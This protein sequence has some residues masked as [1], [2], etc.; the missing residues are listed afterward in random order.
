MS[1]STNTQIV[2]V[3]G[4]VEKL[5]FTVIEEV[6]PAGS[7]TVTACVS[8]LVYS[9]HDNNKA[10]LELLA[11]LAFTEASSDVIF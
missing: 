3:S 6:D 9:D 11:A 2:S 4:I 1:A 10:S 8:T 5:A 7:G